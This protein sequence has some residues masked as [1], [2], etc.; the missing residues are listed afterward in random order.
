M[1]TS[2]VTRPPQQAVPKPALYTAIADLNRDFEVVIDDL[3]KLR[4]L[5]LKP[6]MMDAFI[7]KIEDIRAWSNSELLEIQ[8]D[9]ELKDWGR[10]GQLNRRFD[11]S[12]KDPNDV[13]IEADILR[14]DRTVEAVLNELQRRRQ[15]TAKKPR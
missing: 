7:V 11:A 4:D 2:H 12:L 9:R 1:A 3:R 14:R 8:H 10:W 5:R 6:E 15:R 13:L